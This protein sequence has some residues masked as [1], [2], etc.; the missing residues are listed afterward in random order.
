[1]S[2]SPSLP[3]EDTNEVPDSLSYILQSQHPSV[4]DLL[5][6]TMTEIIAVT[7][8]RNSLSPRLSASTSN[9]DIY[10]HSPENMSANE[11]EVRCSRV[12]RCLFSNEV[13]CCMSDILV[14][15]NSEGHWSGWELNQST[16]HL[17]SSHCVIPLSPPKAK[18]NS[19]AYTSKT[20]NKLHNSTSSLAKSSSTGRVDVSVRYNRGYPYQKEIIPFHFKHF[21]DKMAS[22]YIDLYKRS[23]TYP[24]MEDKLKSIDSSAGPASFS[25]PSVIEPKLLVLGISKPGGS[26]VYRPHYNRQVSFLNITIM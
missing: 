19:L 18:T 10:H 24:N 16:V 8:P 26:E 9:I 21:E 23:H 20:N 25:A 12:K 1:M 7:P 2:S 3:S 22:M 4:T 17:P 15:H 6:L 5:K 14:G 11:S 13:C